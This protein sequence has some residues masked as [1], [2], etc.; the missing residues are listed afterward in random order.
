MLK[1][2]M[3]AIAAG[4]LLVGCG[5]EP[6]PLDTSGPTGL[7]P[8]FAGSK[9]GNH[10]SPLDQIRGENVEH[11]ELAWVHRSG[12]YSE[13][14]DGRA[15]TSFQ[16]VPLV[17]NDL[18]YYCTPYQR[19]FALDPESGEERWSFDPKLRAVGSGGPYPLSCRGVSYWQEKAPVAGRACQK[20][21]LYGTKDSELLALDA[22]SGLLCSDFGD[23]GRVALREG[24]GE[25]GDTPAW[26]YY[27][28]SPPLVLGDLVVLGALVA[29][30]LR[31]DAPSG[32]VRAFD[33]RSGRLVWAWDPVPPGWKTDARPGERYQRGT[34]NVWS[35]L[36][37]DPESG[38]VF[39]PLGNASPDS[40]GG[41]RNG[42]DYY[43]SSIVALDARDGRVV[44]RFQTVHHDVW[45]YDVPS[46]PT[47]VEL[48][49]VGGG[50]PALVQ[51]TKMGHLF[52][53]DRE[54]GEPLYPVEELPVPQGGV[55]EERLSPTQPF[56]TH[57]P[58]LH[59]ARLEPDD[60]FGFTPLDR[61]FCRKQI[62]RHRYDGIFTPPTTQGSLQLPHSAGGM[63][64]GGL[65]IDPAS[66]VL[67]V[68]Q[69][70]AVNV[71]QLI[72]REEFDRL[73][74]GAFEYP[75]E[76][77]PM[78]GTPYG[79]RRQTLLSIFG[80]PCNPPPWGTLSAVELAS[81]ELRWQVP[82]GTTRDK[83]PFPIWL[84]P[85]WRDLGT[86]I[87]GGGLLTA[88]G[89]YFIGATTDRYFRAFDSASGEELWRRRIPF[90]AN[91]IPMT[92]RLRQ[93]SRQFVVVAAGGNVLSTIGDALLAFALPQ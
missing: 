55:A 23:G 3:A 73:D 58:P 42:L 1:W 12:D 25:A 21:I 61:F 75:D 89:L 81:G 56:P 6:P 24:I 88:G 41:D 86:P 18:L 29:D 10:Y 47:L 30:Q 52:I 51:S 44:W 70:H 48:P 13:G 90:N 17:V 57:P 50:R 59:P 22:D 16:A 15:P 78:D 4:A 45:D 80:A 60:A 35:I 72:P 43:S 93:A 31:V 66:G 39:V 69:T 33:A 26:E 67:Y 83:A 8:D 68:A 65:A 77:Y 34:P 87:V 14:G 20:R 63:N 49:G 32:V 91:A 37:G 64:W 85:A 28:T 54:T 27:P 84:I 2:A 19:V 74:P 36:S 5:A 79:V 82:L 62:E 46:Q 40:F 7:W 53:L 92:Y 9:S 11:L 71:T 76:L 38:L